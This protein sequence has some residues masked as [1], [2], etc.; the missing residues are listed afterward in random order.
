MSETKPRILIAGGG[1]GGLRAALTLQRN[2]NIGDA[3][4]TLISKHDY[5]Y[6][7]TLLHKVAIGTLS[8]RKARIFLRKVLDSN[9]IKFIKDKIIEFLPDKNQVR[10]NGGIYEYDYLVI[11]LG[12]K[13]DTFNI[14]GVAEYTHKLSSL[15]AA[16][17]LLHNI[18][19]KFKE[20]VHTHNEH[21]LRVVVCG[22]G[23]TGIE[24][25][26]ELA[27]Q[28]N[29]LC[30][31][32]GIDRNLPKVICVG[33]SEQ[34]VPMFPEY[35]S[36]IAKT[37]MQKLGVE[38]VRGS[39]KECR[40][41]GVLVE[42][43]GGERFIEA[44]T[45]LWS[46]GVR[47]N[48]IVEK[49]CIPNKRG[50]IPVTPELRCKEYSNIFVVGDCA[51]AASRDVIHAPTAQL[52]AQMGDY[53]GEMLI[54]I[55]NNKADLPPFAFKHRGTVCSIG[56]KDG[57][58]VIYKKGVTGEVAAFIKN[59]IENKWLYGIGGLSMV[60]KKGQFRYRS[61]D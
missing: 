12:F 16:L 58:G 52:S 15:N 40:A 7:T 43:D 23:F 57:V 17:K 13:P 5:H 1:Y 42:E 49:S 18:E 9:K 3:D 55:L 25:A 22:T 2:L 33:R 56:H 59:T 46:T 41:N 48:D 34:I 26:A 53:V 38:F 54:R 28:L 32:C 21:D 50:R 31:V 45:I 44:N 20:F 8:D 51:F 24:F 36:R 37:K 10:G 30:L 61:S 29:E 47:G 39:V 35:L 6:Q 11:G 27:N 4:I 60:F 19:T 14:P